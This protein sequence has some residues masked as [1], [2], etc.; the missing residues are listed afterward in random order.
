MVPPASLAISHSQEYIYK[1]GELNLQRFFFLPPRLFGHVVTVCYSWSRRGIV[2]V[3]TIPYH[4]ES[5][6]G[7]FITKP[8]ESEIRPISSEGL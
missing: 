4:T 3:Y 2:S 1:F 7:D 8:N 6:L 5:F